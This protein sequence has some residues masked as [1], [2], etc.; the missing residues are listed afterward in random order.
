MSAKFAISGLQQIK[1]F[2]N[3]GYDIIIPDYGITNKILL[4]DSNF[5]VD[6]VMW[7]KFGSSSI[8][9]REV[10]VTAI[11]QGFD[12]KKYFFEGWSWFKSFYSPS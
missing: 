7:P 4:C 9:M 10:I 1:I 5:I 12:Q 2:W 8:S 6:K 3:K 11:L